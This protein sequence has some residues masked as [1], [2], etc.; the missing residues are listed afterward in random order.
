MSQIKLLCIDDKNKPEDIPFT[1]WVEEDVLYTLKD[2]A[3]LTMQNNKL[4]VQID[5]INLKDLLLQHEYFS[6]NRFAIKHEDLEAFTQI[7]TASGKKDSMTT[8]D[9]NKLFNI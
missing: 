6:L 8:E 1:H 9:L 7:I 4:G 5:E 3:S 2:V